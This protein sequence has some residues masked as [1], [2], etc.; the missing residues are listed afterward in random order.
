MKKREENWK[1]KFLKG[2]LHLTDKGKISR[3]FAFKDASGKFVLSTGERGGPIKDAF[4]L[5]QLEELPFARTL[6]GAKI[7]VALY[8]ASWNG[9]MISP[10]FLS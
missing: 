5:N 10:M 4:G 9:N 7:M 3:I 2:Q 8:F 6:A 1:F